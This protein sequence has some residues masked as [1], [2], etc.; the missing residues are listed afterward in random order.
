M[1]DAEGA[2]HYETRIDPDK[3]DAN[4]QPV[5]QVAS[6]SRATLSCQ[7]PPKDSEVK[8]DQVITDPRP[9]PWR[10]P[11]MGLYARSGVRKHRVELQRQHEV[12]VRQS[13]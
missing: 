12:V 13:T 11:C 8:A 1:A 4:V 3:D 10:G 2:A 9:L 6:G 7:C 5:P